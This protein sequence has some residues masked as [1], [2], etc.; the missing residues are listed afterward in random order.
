MNHIIS[1]PIDK[2]LAEFIGKK[3]SENGITFYNRK[4][5]DGSAITVLV[6]TNPSEK[7]YSVAESILVSDQILL[8]TKNI[9]KEFGEV[10]IAASLSEKHVIITRENDI[11]TL[12]TGNILKDFEIA[13]REEILE[14][15]ISYTQGKNISKKRVDIDK[16]FPVKGIGTVVL[17]VVTEG[18]ILQHDKLFHSSG[19]EIEIKSIQSQDIDLKEA[20]EGA[21]VGLGLKGIEHDEI[22]KG[23]ILSSKKP[24]QIQKFIAKLNKSSFAKEDISSQKFY[25]IV[26]NFSHSNA[27][28]HEKDGL[29][30][31]SLEKMLPVFEGDK[32]FLIRNSP[33]RIFASGAVEALL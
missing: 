20:G 2:N 32:F 7:F 29:Y 6:P 5:P 23:S 33:P 22:E 28:V 4:A 19:K 16:A 24:V 21:R 11:S 26:M 25:L 3:S 12:L 15:I 27:R 18:T 30:E 31:I 10:L 14:R 13:N 1:V 17:G 9:D 8:S